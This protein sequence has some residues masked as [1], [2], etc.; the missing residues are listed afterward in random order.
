MPKIYF[1]DGVLTAESYV[2]VTRQYTCKKGT[3]STITLELPEGVTYQGTI[4]MNLQCPCCGEQVAIPAGKHSI[5][6]E[7]V[8]VSEYDESN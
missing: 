4:S 1:K 7:G 8:L 2:K 5:N 6:S 3:T